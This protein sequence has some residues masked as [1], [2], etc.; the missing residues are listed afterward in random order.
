[1][2]T[3]VPEPATG[4]A[5]A[6]GFAPGARVASLAGE[7][8]LE[9]LLGRGKSGYSWL[10]RFATGRPCVYKRMH[11]EP[12]AYYTF[13]GNK[14]DHE[15]RGWQ[16]LSRAGIPM[17]GPLCFD[18]QDG[19]LVKAFVNGPTGCGLAADGAVDAPILGQLLDMAR[20]AREAGLNLDWFPPNFVLE[21]GVLYYIDYEANPFDARW[22]LEEWGLYYWLNRE[23]MAAF[24]RGAGMDLLEEPGRP[25]I[26][27]RSGLEAR[28][29][30]ILAGEDAR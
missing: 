27:L 4:L 3:P 10:A 23:G 20:K 30:A 7:L 22:S 8:R 2:S 5:P 12:C 28:V 17:P 26:P 21:G 11:D 19:Y 1:M 29:T 25:G 6:T 9:R 13:D 15:Q 16:A 24:R 18:P 14:V